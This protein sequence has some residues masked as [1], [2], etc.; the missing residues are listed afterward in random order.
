[1]AVTRPEF[2]PTLPGA[3]RERFGIPPPATL[4]VAAVVALAAVA[5][6][7]YVLTRPNIWGE[8][9]VREGGPVFNMIYPGDGAMRVADT[10]AGEL[11]RLEG[12]RKG[13]EV[14]VVVKPLELPRF[15]GDVTHGLLPVYADRFVEAE[16][17]AMPGLELAQEGRA[18]VNNAVGYEVGYERITDSE[19]FT[20]RD[21]LLVPDDPEEGRGAVLLSLR[22]RKGSGE[23]LTPPERNL[24][25]LARKTYRSFRFG[26]DRG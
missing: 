2:G 14:S 17:R 18:R 5:G 8:R 22:Q 19:R 10:G 23:K 7:I 11:L 13:L 25:Y 16:K 6:I 4:A 26:I 1:M 15:D 9:I 24:A 20:G 3:L 21:V 12:R